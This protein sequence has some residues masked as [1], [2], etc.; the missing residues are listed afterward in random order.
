MVELL[1]WEMTLK[2]RLN[3]G[4]A[5]PIISGRTIN[6]MFF[7]G[8]SEL[9]REYAQHLKQALSTYTYMGT[10]STAAPQH[11]LPPLYGNFIHYLLS[12]LDEAP[13]LHHDHLMELAKFKFLADDNMV[14]D[15]ETLKSDYVEFLKKR[16]VN[17]INDKNIPSHLLNSVAY[18]WTSLT[19]SDLPR[20]V[21]FP[22]MD[23]DHPLMVL[24]SIPFPIYLT[25]SQH[26]FIELALAMAG[27][28]PYTGVC[29]WWEKSEEPLI[30]HS[31]SLQKAVEDYEPDP[32][33]PLVFH[34]HGYDAYP[35]SLVLTEDDYLNYLLTIVR[36][37][38]TESD[39][40]PSIVREAISISTLLV[41]G[42]DLHSW[43]F[44]TL[45]MGIIQDMKHEHLNVSVQ[46]DPGGLQ[47]IYFERYLEDSANC[48][49]YWGII[50]EYIHRLHAIW[51]NNLL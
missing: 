46:V 23:A 24:A 26:N 32:D 3:T 17:I 29:G 34:L 18:N 7:D 33:H 31:L 49:V 36:S 51:S 20:R 14:K 42:Y 39:P 8:Q 5:I 50:E 9:V 48:Q 25:S 16:F 19:L 21:G 12:D 38:S 6:D 40:I 28:E 15:T 35:Q 45:Y 22:Q 41:L 27:K 2:R 10:S 13:R 11:E 30:Y 44:R 4:H 43:D 1:P 47:K 37:R